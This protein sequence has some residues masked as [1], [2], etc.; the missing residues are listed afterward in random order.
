ME[1]LIKAGLSAAVYTQTTDVEGEVNGFMTYD[2]KVMKMPLEKLKEVN[3]KMYDV[4]PVE[5]VLK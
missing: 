3:E 1:E 2:R 5:S 4:Q